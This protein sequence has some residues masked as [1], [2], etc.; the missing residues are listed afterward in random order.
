VKINVSTHLNGH[1]TR[2]AR[3]ALEADAGIVDPRR[4]LG[5]ARDAMA[6]EATRLLTLIAG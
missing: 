6:A 4:Y 5:P 3:A 2:A 1:F